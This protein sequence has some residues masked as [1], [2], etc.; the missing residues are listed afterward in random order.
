MKKIVFIFLLLSY[1]LYAQKIVISVSIE[2]QKFI[3]EKIAKTKVKVKSIYQGSDF[4]IK[5]KKL[6]L[7]EVAE[8]TLFMT[9]DLEL[10]QK[11][12]KEL[13][14]INTNLEI[15]DISKDVRKIKTRGVSNPYIW[16]D[17]LKTRAMAKTVFFKL[18]DMDPKNREFYK[19]NYEVFSQE[20]DDLYIRIKTILSTSSFGVYVF[21]DFWDYYLNR[22][23]F[24]FYKIEKRILDADEISSF[25]KTSKKRDAKILLVDSKTPVKTLRSIANNSSLRIV[26]SDIYSY[27]FM[28][29]LI[30]LS[31]EISKK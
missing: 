30:I 20:L 15:F 26:T 6:V 28:G 17:P 19:K 10:E 31:Q 1:T 7:N 8:S 25:I 29:D 4:K 2:P 11:I 27:A 18:S 13:K 3:I 12:L 21:D 24:P 23:D 9:M 22:F 14:K 5:F 16:L